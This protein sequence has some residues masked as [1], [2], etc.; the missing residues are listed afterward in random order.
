MAAQENIQLTLMCED[1]ELCC[2]AGVLMCIWYFF[3]FIYNA[4][5]C[6]SSLYLSAYRIKCVVMHGCTY[7]IVNFQ[8]AISSKQLFNH[9]TE[10]VFKLKYHM[11]LNV[12]MKFNT[13]HPSLLPAA[14]SSEEDSRH[15]WD[16]SAA[17]HQ[18]GKNT[19][20]FQLLSHYL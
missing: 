6:S 2:L 13:T 9:T 1:E 4:K 20:F 7:Y 12:G 14:E 15:S 8:S 3:S 10:N 19:F 17:R 11:W 18:D 16:H 5:H